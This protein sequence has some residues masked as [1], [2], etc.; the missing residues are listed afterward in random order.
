M[1]SLNRLEE[2]GAA[3]DWR[4]S[5]LMCMKSEVIIAFVEP[6][7][8]IEVVKLDLEKVAKLKDKRKDDKND[9]LSDI[10]ESP[11]PSETSDEPPEPPANEPDAPD[12][13]NDAE[14]DD[15]YPDDIPCQLSAAVDR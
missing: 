1:L 3:Y 7:N 14:I 6:W 11:N 12:G 9:N 10:S 8:G 2:L 5:S 13:L 4:T 15:D